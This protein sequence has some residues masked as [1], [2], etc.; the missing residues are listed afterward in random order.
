MDGD[1]KVLEELRNI[2]F[3]IYAMGLLIAAAAGFALS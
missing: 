3:A 2:R 1:R